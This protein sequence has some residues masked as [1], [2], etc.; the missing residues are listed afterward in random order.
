MYHLYSILLSGH[1]LHSAFSVSLANALLERDSGWKDNFAPLR[2][3]ILSGEGPILHTSYSCS[4]TGLNFVSPEMNFTHRRDEGYSSP[5]WRFLTTEMKVG[6]VA[7][8]FKSM[9][10][11]SSDKQRLCLPRIALLFVPNSTSV[12]DK[13]RLWLGNNYQP[14]GYFIFPT[15]RT[16]VTYPSSGH[17]RNR[18]KIVPSAA[19]PF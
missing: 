8:Y 15:E 6:K 2:E 13:C 11:N 19:I 17:I 3:G 7:A 4:T 10:D 16:E 5:R 14:S 1:F 9:T 12:W 18:C